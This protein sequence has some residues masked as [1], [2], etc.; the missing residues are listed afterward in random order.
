MQIKEA[1]LCQPSQFRSLPLPCLPLF[2]KMSSEAKG[3]NGSLSREDM[4]V[5]LMKRFDYNKDGRLSR[6]ELA[7]AFRSFGSRC[8]SWR[9]KLAMYHA[10]Y[11]A[12][13]FIY[14]D[15]M[16]KLVDYFCKKGFTII[17]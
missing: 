17:D 2:Q 8:P 14:G 16:T 5:L 3:A 1:K 13:G 10:D 11:D 7:M 4:K 12:D 9:A 15:E 6:D